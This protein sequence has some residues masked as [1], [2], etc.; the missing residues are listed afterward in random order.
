MNTE[1][2]DTILKD[3][4]LYLKRDSKGI[5]ADLQEADLQEAD[6]RGADLRGPICRGI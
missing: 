6:L 3:H 5:R 1:Q 4:A 2:L